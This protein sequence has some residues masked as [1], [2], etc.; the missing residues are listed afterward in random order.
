MTS[1]TDTT[2]TIVEVRPGLWA[3]GQVADVDLDR[4]VAITGSRAST[5]YGN[6]VATDFGHDIA[7]AGWHVV[8]TGGFGID[9]AALNGALQAP[10]AAPVIWGV[11]SLDR[12]YPSA[13]R[14]LFERVL[15]SGGLILSG[16]DPANGPSYPTRARMIDAMDAMLCQARAAVIVEA[17]HRSL[18]GTRAALT[19]TPVFAVPGSVRNPTS[20]GTHRLIAQGQARLVTCA[21]D[22]LAQLEAG[23]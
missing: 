1:S 22:V 17:A 21:D 7:N 11:S 15:R 6:H 4:L 16:D 14:D 8:T 9:T 23:E 2:A 18:P 13:N 12:P 5:H 20:V 3:K 19:S 10:G